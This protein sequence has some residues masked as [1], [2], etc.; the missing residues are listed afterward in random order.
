MIIQGSWCFSLYM[1]D[2]FEI[3]IFPCRFDSTQKK[4]FNMNLFHFLYDKSKHDKKIIS[5]LSDYV[6]L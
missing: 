6:A 3:C 1:C 4:S 5:D 2:E